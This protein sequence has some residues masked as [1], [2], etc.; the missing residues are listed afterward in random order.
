MTKKIII[1]CFTLLSILSMM[2]SSQKDENVQTIDEFIDDQK[3]IY[4]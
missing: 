2:A 4:Q 3:K 1:I